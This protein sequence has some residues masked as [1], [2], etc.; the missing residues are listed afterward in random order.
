MSDWSPPSPRGPVLK[1]GVGFVESSP[2]AGAGA[3]AHALEGSAAP[4]DSLGWLSDLATLLKLR[5]N[6]VVLVTTFVGFRVA[7][8][9]LQLGV[10]GEVPL[11]G[12]EIL[13]HALFGTLLLGC[14][15]SVL[16]QLVEREH[17]GKMERTRS[18]PLASGRMSPSSA[19]ALGVVLNVGGIAY[20]T[21]LVNPLCAAVGALTS[22]LYIFAYTPLKR[23]S[24]LSLIVGAVAGAMPPLIGWA[25]ATGELRGA[26]WTLFTIQFIWQVPHFLAIAWIYREDY[27]R[28]GFPLLTVVDR[29]GLTTRVQVVAWSL[30][31]LPA[32]LALPA[33]FHL[34][35]MPYFLVALASGLVFLAAA[36]LFALLLT[37]RAAR[38]LVIVSILYLPV[39]FLTLIWSV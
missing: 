38:V 14:G 27:R 8:A 5:V 34:G 19:Q 7:E 11:V 23:L 24:S 31:L 6:F 13:L 10:I 4:I 2:G 20:L 18:R 32:S 26:V 28:A 25:A 37:T 33:L 3:E 21:F 1:Q 17:D 9:S 39:L 36:A 22:A 30:A 12:V 29:T 15:A 16:N 35:G